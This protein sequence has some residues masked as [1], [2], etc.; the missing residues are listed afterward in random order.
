MRYP[1]R[2]IEVDLPIKRISAH[3]RREKSIRHG[4]ISTLHI[5]WA[6]RPLAACRAVLCAS[7]WPDPADEECPQAFRDAAA[8]AMN[9]FAKAVGTSES[10]RK[11]MGQNASV[12]YPTLL[13]VPADGSNPNH[14]EP[15]RHLLLD[16]IA[17]FA[18]W[19]AS[20]DPDFLET[21]RSLTQ[22]AHEALG[23]EPGTRP[24]VVDPFAGGGSIP[25]EALRVGADAF[26]SDLNPVAVLLNKVVLE[27]I[28]KYGQRLADAVREAGQWIKEE[29]EKELGE[30][31][32]KDPD[33]ATPI[34]YLWARTITCEGPGCGAEVP[35]MR[36]LWL[37]K[38]AGRSIA[39]KAIPY[40]GDVP[41]AHR[42]VLFVVVERKGKN[43]VCIDAPEPL[44]DMIG[45]PV[46]DVNPDQGT[47]Q[48]GSAT[49][50]FCGHT[51]P[52][53]S[54]RKQLKAKRGGAVYPPEALYRGGQGPRLFAVVTTRPAERGRFY[55]LP[56]ESDIAA[57]QEAA[58]ELERRKAAHKRP[59]S[60]VPDEPL[61]VMSGVFNAPLYGM[62]SW[63][64]LFTGRQALVLTTLSR[65]VR[66]GVRFEN[67][68]GD[69]HN[70]LNRAVRTCL[71]LALSRQSDYTSSLCSWHLTGE[72]INHTFGRQALPMIW[73]FAEVFPFSGSTGEFA[74][75]LEWVLRVLVTNLH[76]PCAGSGEQASAAAHP[77]PDDA[78]R[79]FFT[80][81]PYYNAVPYADLSDF[82]Y[83]W[84]RRT[85][86]GVEPQLFSYPLSPKPDEICEMAGWDPHR[87]AEK[88]GKWFETR[89][90]E[91][92][93][94]GRRVLSPDGI[95]AVVF[96]HKSTSG[97]EAQLQAM[98]D[99]G[100]TMTASWPI[101]TEM[102]SR[103]RAMNSAA[104]ASSVHLVCRPRENPD[105]SL[106]TDDIGDWREVLRELP[107]R[108]RAWMPRLAEE[109]VVGADAIF[110]CLGPALEIFSRY[111]RVEKA[112]G[113]VVT[114]REYLEE[115]WAAVSKEAL[116]MI[117][118]EA[119]T[120]GFEEDARLTA[121]WLWTLST[122]V[123][124]AG[125]PRPRMPVAVASG[126]ATLPSMTVSGSATVSS[127]AEV[128]DVTISTDSDESAATAPVKSTGYTI[129]Y[130]AARKIAQGL[131]ANLEALPH[132]VEVKGDKATLLP[133][134]QRVKHLFGKDESVGTST[135]RKKKARSKQMS[136]FAALEE[137][138][139][140]EFG[141]EEER[142]ADPS[143]LTPPAGSTVLDRVHQAMVLFGA[144]RGEALKRFL[145]DDGIGAD[146]RLWTLAQALSALYPPATEE[147]RWVDGVLARKKGL[148][149]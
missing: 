140:E 8:E 143:T 90:A 11:I 135:G 7:L 81:P 129:E 3:A 52:V 15:L 67:Q 103:L 106:R 2:L 73:D 33:G 9:T 35:L 51:T 27:Y 122:S 31:Y 18:A 75:A 82:F 96:A 42:A 58:R 47:V 134:S 55:R 74:G 84:L 64:S 68:E 43:W 93:R 144:G 48:R 121:M 87:Y 41:G 65:L 16:F 13:K 141:W 62:T 148:G 14:W 32:K 111:S 5:W 97:W 59:L 105:G 83:V 4:H 24:L 23:G 100:W 70:G 91:A 12:F 95:G 22:A 109:G 130:D 132:L 56:T 139:Q 17:E 37:A 1:K 128:T 61:P 112:S 101:D 53:A 117:F 118:A 79:C 36:S 138:E 26:A 86:L 124:G 127:N 142:P 40:E 57:A 49:C 110:A 126:G 99:A 108:I 114:L 72:K 80:D 46:D 89:M 116:S 113:D 19:E 29:A 85:L 94:E 39:L 133:V 69:K 92:M 38:K 88:N 10:V 119:D 146:A 28:P 77:L 60:L 145:V 25:L 44:R 147:K 102:G 45:K 131:G 50:P 21:A 30:F 76:L 149:F 104:L 54:V 107:E 6:R 125:K 71:A 66:E 136:L 120:A 78:A 115:V 34:A 123:N 63:G 20:T 137:A 98:V